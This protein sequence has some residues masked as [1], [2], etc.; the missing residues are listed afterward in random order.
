[1]SKDETIGSTVGNRIRARRIAL[2]ISQDELAK[3]LGYKSRSSINK[4][5]LNAQ[6]LTQSKIKAIADAL[7]TTPAYIMGWDEQQPEL[8]PGVIP[9]TTHRIPLLGRIACGTPIMATEDREVYVE[10]GTDI[11]ADFALQAAGDSM[12]GARIRDGDLVFIRSQP[13]VENG[14]IAAVIINDEATLK[15][16]AWYPDRQL[17]ILKPEN[18]KY[19][20]LIY[21][22]EQLSEVRILG[23][24]VAFQ[25]SL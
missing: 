17:L 3:R 19:A 16:V 4:I 13:T 22:G 18:P 5:E 15:R 23:K 21:T 10:A 1:M 6:N 20:D 9:I 24:A 14:E 7:E 25:S 12:I 11:H 8:P 2:D